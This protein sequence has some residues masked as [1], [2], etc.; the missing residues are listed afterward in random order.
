MQT[1]FTRNKQKNI[2]FV[3]H[4]SYLTDYTRMPELH[5]LPVPSQLSGTSRHST[6]GSWCIAASKPTLVSPAICPASTG[7]V[8]LRGYCWSGWQLIFPFF[9]EWTSTFKRYLQLMSPGEKWCC[10]LIAPKLLS[11]LMLYICHITQVS[12]I[13]F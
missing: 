2:I 12:F 9:Y 4:L 5:L 11:S 3:W 13:Y 6:I 1:N 8:Q 7:P 10:K